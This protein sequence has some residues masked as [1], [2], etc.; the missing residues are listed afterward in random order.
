MIIREELNTWDF[1]DEDLQEGIDGIT[2]VLDR[3]HEYK[4]EIEDINYGIEKE[5]AEEIA[6]KIFDICD[7]PYLADYIDDISAILDKLG[8]YYTDSNYI[9]NII[10]DIRLLI[11]KVLHQLEEEQKYRF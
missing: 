1:S 11:Y 10:I 3:L 4:K 9:V 5:R 8:R 6:D 2:D 7:V